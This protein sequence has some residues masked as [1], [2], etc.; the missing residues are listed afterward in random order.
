MSSNQRPSAWTTPDAHRTYVSGVLWAAGL[1]M[2]AIL[3][4]AVN[5]GG[6]HLGVR[7]D[8]AGWVFLAAALVGGWNFFPK[9]VRS[10]AKLKL[11]MNFLM[12]I[13]IIGAVI[14]GEP[15][16]AAAIAFLF[17]FA[18]LLEHSAVVRARNS[19]DGLLRLAPEE[20]RIVD[21]DGAER[22]VPASQ[23]RS[24]QRVRV[25]PGDKVPI[26]GTV[27]SGRSAVN[28]A[29]VTGESLPVTKNPGDPVFASTLNTDGFLEIEATTNAG[30]TT[31]DQVA[32][33]VRKAQ[34]NRSSTE[35]FVDR[36]A[37][38]YTPAVTI[39]AV[40]VMVLPPLLGLGSGLTWFVRGLTL[41]VIACPCALVI[42][43][44]VT[45]VS[46]L[47]S[48]ARHGVLIKGGEYVESFGATCAI[49]FDKTGTLTTGQL[50]VTDIV[51]LIED[52]PEWLDLVA[53]LESRSEHPIAEAIVNYAGGREQVPIS[54]SDAVVTDF[55][56]HA[57]L[58]VTGTV[59][60][61]HWSVGTV[62]LMGQTGCAGLDSVA[63][64]RFGALEQQGKTV[65]VVCRDKQAV[66]LIALSDT[67]RP[68]ATAVLAQ[69]R[70]QGIHYQALLTGDQLFAAQQVGDAVGVDEIRAGLKPAQKVEAVRA[71]QRT[72]KGGVA[73]V[74]D[75]VNDAPALA[76]ASVGIAMG[77]A[78]SP[79]AIETANV[80]LMADD[81]RMLPY[82]RRVSRSARRTVRFNIA[83]ALILKGVLA[84][85]ALSGFVSLLVAV[86][87]GDLG[88]SIVVTLNAMRLARMNP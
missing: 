58:G 41:L 18:E 54:A 38:Y 15:L 26:D 65:V 39:A 77:G 2:S 63:T 87:V 74:G 31:L 14:I 35:Q 12:T 45:I 62:D 66:G 71:L 28:Q 53:T 57:G 13:A 72:H 50:Q 9:G 37:R 51:R 79:A 17:S 34:A 73:M 85:G 43:T 46:A 48:A 8:P 23:L 27:V 5:A 52:E 69:L 61:V 44:P 4:G 67:M 40:L 86:L 64:D 82:A 30:E 56:A 10:A 21:A 36:F 7:T 88:A 29:N 6:P 16:E 75:G 47:T 3:A 55:R 81:L 20:A 59:E 32:D 70:A 42:A 84:V 49:A 25:R 83:V 22:V 78:G 60:G 19:I 24:G 76:A 11:D 1:L 80:A 68:E 33:M